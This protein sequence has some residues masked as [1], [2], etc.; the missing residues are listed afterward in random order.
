MA[1]DQTASIR[2]R[3]LGG[4]K[5]AIEAEAVAKA[6]DNVKDKTETLALASMYA[7]DRL[8]KLNR[9]L[10]KLQANLAG[11]SFGFR[12]LSI[13]MTATSIIAWS[14]ASVTLPALALALYHVAGAT[15]VVAAAFTAG[16]IGAFV[17][18]G[19]MA[20]AVVDRFKQMSG[21]IGSAANELKNAGYL[22]RGAFRDATAGGADALM[23]GLARGLAK[24]AP[25]LRSLEGS[26]TAMGQAFGD[27]FDHLFSE[28]ASM[29]PELRQMFRRL[30]PVI[31]ST[32]RMLGSM[33]R[34]FVQLAT[35]G[36]PL[37]ADAFDWLADKMTG[38][39]D[40]FTDSKVNGALGTIKRFVAG[41]K[42]FWQS[43]TAPI[44]KELGPAIKEFGVAWA[45]VADDVGRSL[46]AIVAGFIQFGRDILPM[47]VSGVKLLSDVLGGNGDRFAKVLAFVVVLSATLKTFAFL[48]GAAKAAMVI[49]RGVIWTVYTAMWALSAN[50]LGAL[51]LSIATVGAAFYLAYKN[52]KVF[53]DAVNSLVPSADDS[54]AK[55]FTRGRNN[56]WRSLTPDSWSPDWRSM[57]PGHAGGGTMVQGGW[58]EVG[59]RGKEL[60][61]VPKAATI[62][63]AAESRSIAAHDR[64]P[65]AE[66]DQGPRERL[67]QPINF[68]VGGRVLAQVVEEVRLA[69]AKLE[70]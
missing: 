28:L 6:I 10:L 1:A 21:V 51:L 45:D 52:V 33:L 37:V 63:T 12:R 22:V 43:F 56:W 61:H 57:I 49:W 20:V 55:Q 25:L 69:D 23:R 44:K 8:Q 41:A 42:R 59:E 34:L 14:L 18:A 30:I 39:T 58:T 70:G 32:G 62:F 66:R 67:L 47:V 24:L 31:D 48:V 60:I 50:P 5:A 27:M 7:N 29:G 11:V 16:L 53:R 54:P 3:I 38:W 40:S 9:T 13:S 64:R 4:I 36:A 17:A 68:R 15:L 65:T 46:G 2:I 26:F 35:V 19:L